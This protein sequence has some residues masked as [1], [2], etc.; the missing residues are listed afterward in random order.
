MESPV[1]FNP[2]FMKWLIQSFV[3]EFITEGS[4]GFVSNNKNYEYRAYLFP[5]IERY[6]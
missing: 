1:K 3:F 5:C 4:F 2:T 6:W